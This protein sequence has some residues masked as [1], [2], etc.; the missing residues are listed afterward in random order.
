[1]WSEWRVSG[2]Y[3]WTKLKISSVSRGSAI[4]MLEICKGFFSIKTPGDLVLLRHDT[5]VPKPRCLGNLFLSPL[6]VPYMHTVPSSLM[7]TCPIMH[8]CPLH[9]PYMHT[10]IHVPMQV[11]YMHPCPLHAYCPPLSPTCILF[12]LLLNGKEWQRK[13]YQNNTW[14][15]VTEPCLLLY[16]SARRGIAFVLQFLEE[17]EQSPVSRKYNDYFRK[18]IDLG[19]S[20][21]SK[22]KKTALGKGRSPPP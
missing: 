9:I 16:I 17:I 2:T 1:M 13:T 14:L 11:P 6:S 20:K 12:P 22:T 7:H 8:T 4:D 18:K 15:L 5:R 21:P 3:H 19:E 10:C